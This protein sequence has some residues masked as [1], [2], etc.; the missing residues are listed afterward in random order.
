MRSILIQFQSKKK[1][2][3]KTAVEKYDFCLREMCFLMPC[4][5][6]CKI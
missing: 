4:K 1:K 3:R 6:Q 5:D 2:K